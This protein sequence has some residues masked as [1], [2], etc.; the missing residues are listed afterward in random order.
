M[1]P[2]PV[3]RGKQGV[4]TLFSAFLAGLAFVAPVLLSFIVLAW[5]FTQLETLVGPYS[6]F[7]RLLRSAGD[8][9]TGQGGGPLFSFAI[10]VSI[11]VAIITALGWVVKTRAKQVLEDAVDGA[12]G[13]I[14]LIGGVYRPV[15]QL[16]RSMGGNKEEQMATMGVCRVMFGGGV[17]A[18]AFLASPDTFDLGSG[19]CKLVLIPTAPVPIG[20]ALL[21]FPVDKVQ[22]ISSMKFDDLAKLYLTMGMTPPPQMR[23]EVSVKPAEMGRVSP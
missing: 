12:I 17:E 20:G 18:V 3:R 4:G 21:L 13:R 5:V 9:F 16:V 11:L 14:P 10:G 7:G 2:K 1:M 19:P 23:A 15:A 6:G 22:T 8:L